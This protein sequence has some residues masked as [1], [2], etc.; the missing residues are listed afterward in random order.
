[1][2]RD[3]DKISPG[4]KFNPGSNYTCNV[5]FMLFSTESMRKKFEFAINTENY[6]T[7]DCIKVIYDIHRTW[8]RIWRVCAFFNILYSFWQYKKIIL[9]QSQMT[10]KLLF[11]FSTQRLAITC[12]R[13]LIVYETFIETLETI[14]KPPWINWAT[15]ICHR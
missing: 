9:D 11:S 3:R 6:L 7:W 5:P 8:I 2:T 14:Y 12:M 13:F 15:A 10:R 1:M 4:V